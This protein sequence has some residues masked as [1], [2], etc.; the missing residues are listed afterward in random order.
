MVDWSP[1]GS[2]PPMNDMDWSKEFEKYSHS[3]EFIYINSHFTVSDFKQIFWLE[4]IHRFLGRTIGVVFMLPFF[5]FFIR[6]MFP[7]RFVPKMLILLFLGAIQGLVGWLMVKS[8][9]VKNP[10]VSHYRLTLHLI[11]AFTVLGFTFWYALDLLYPYCNPGKN[12]KLKR[13]TIILLSVI[14][15]QIIYGAFVAGLKAGY[16]YPTYPKMGDRWIPEEVHG[17]LSPMWKNFVQGQ[18]GVQFVHR[19]LAL[20]VLFFSVFLFLKIKSTLQIPLQ[21]K[22]IT[23]LVVVVSIQFILG[24]TTITL[25]VPIFAAI[26]HQVGAF[27]L[28]CITIF[29]IHGFSHGGINYENNKNDMINPL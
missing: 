23:W 7:K 6:K 18:A 8:G 13:L 29:L 20:V 27:L 5:Y 17:Q 19:C 24:I 28:F 16:L 2:F 25:G 1:V 21:R 12:K 14:I 15:L 10:H 3:P 4:Y 22:L 9:L 11:I 26:A